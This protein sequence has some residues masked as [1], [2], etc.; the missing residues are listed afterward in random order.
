ML[1]SGSGFTLTRR[2]AHVGGGGTRTVLLPSLGRHASTT[3]IYDTRN[4]SL[5]FGDFPD[6]VNAPPHGVIGGE[7]GEASEASPNESNVSLEIEV[8]MNS[9]AESLAALPSS[10]EEAGFGKKTPK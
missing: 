3:A 9:R 8:P 4:N 10:L 7:R 6:Y 1:D 5:Q 2:G